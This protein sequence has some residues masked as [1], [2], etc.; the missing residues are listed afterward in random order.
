MSKIRNSLLF[1]PVSLFVVSCQTVVSQQPSECFAFIPPAWWEPV[2][3]YPIPLED[4]ALSWQKALVGQSGQL[5]KANDKPTD[6]KHI[7][8]ECERRHNEAR[9]RRKLLGVL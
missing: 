7:W 1:L 3:S 4:D 8:Q 5:K 2:A 6:I 9:P